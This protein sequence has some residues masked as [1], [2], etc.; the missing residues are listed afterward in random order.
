MPGRPAV[1][2]NLAATHRSLWFGSRREPA[3][4]K[5]FGNEEEN[6]AGG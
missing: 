2:E 3:T 6:P 1:E 4:G 5:F